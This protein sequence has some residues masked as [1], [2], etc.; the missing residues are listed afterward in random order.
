MPYSNQRAG[1]QLLCMDFILFYGVRGREVRGGGGVNGG[2]SKGR[3]WLTPLI[4]YI[5]IGMYTY[6]T[7]GY[8]FCLPFGL[9]HL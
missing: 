3:E 9:S 2:V 7:N 5:L 8:C 1:C 6:C 4:S